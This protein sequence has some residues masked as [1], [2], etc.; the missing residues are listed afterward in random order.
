LREEKGKSGYSYSRF[1]LFLP[2]KAVAGVGGPATPILDKQFA[3]NANGC[4]HLL[5]AIR[6]PTPLC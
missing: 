4:W 5:L 3:P 2:S 6:K 1:S